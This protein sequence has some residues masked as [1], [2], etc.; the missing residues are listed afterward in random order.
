M[1]KVGVIIISGLD[2][3]DSND[4]LQSATDAQSAGITLM[5]IGIG[6]GDEDDLNNQLQ[7]IAS[8]PTDDYYKKV[9]RYRELNSSLID[10]IMPTVCAI[11]TGRS[12]KFSNPRLM[13]FVRTCVDCYDHDNSTKQQK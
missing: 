13:I 10:A 5:V 4:V 12:F 1:G 2:T 3:D 8:S 7:T 9:S 11:Y 6:V